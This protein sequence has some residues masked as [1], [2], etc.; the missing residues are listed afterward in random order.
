M[1]RRSPS[2]K[3][4]RKHIEIKYDV[5]KMKRAYQ[6]DCAVILAGTKSRRIF[7]NP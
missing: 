3:K 7:A 5:K 4:S 1:A 6:D 2:K